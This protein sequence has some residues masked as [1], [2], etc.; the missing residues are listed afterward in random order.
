MKKI[1]IV[2]DEELLRKGSKRML[3]ARGYVTQTAEDGREALEALADFRPDLI[4][5]DINM[6][7]INGFELCRRIRDDNGYQNIPIIAYS[8]LSE[9]EN[10]ARQAGADDYIQKPFKPAELY[11]KVEQ[12]L[13]E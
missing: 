7:E 4:L 6:P 12:L 13:G 1:L 8:G 3:E 11:E 2:D 10:E 9:N 5:T